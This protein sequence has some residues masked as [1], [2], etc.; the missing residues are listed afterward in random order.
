MNKI[1]KVR[2]YLKLSGYSE[3]QI[4]KSISNEKYLDM[5]HGLILTYEDEISNL[6]IGINPV[7]NY[8]NLDNKKIK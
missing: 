5:I 2:R 6:D 1:E 3:D 8:A 7:E 4:N